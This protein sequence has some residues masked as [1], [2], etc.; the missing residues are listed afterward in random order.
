M[1]TPES[2]AL[3]ACLAGASFLAPGTLADVSLVEYRV[4]RDG[5]LGTTLPAGST[6]DPATGLGALTL[7]FDTAGPHYGGLFVDHEL[8]EALNTFFNETG[9]TSAGALPAGL[10]YEIDE[11]DLVTGNIYA[12]F[13][14]NTLDNGVGTPNTVFPDDVSMALMWNIVLAAGETAA[15]E[16]VVSENPLA[17]FYLIHT[18]P[19]SQEALYFGS[20]LTIRASPNPSG[21]EIPEPGTVAAGLAFAALA[22]GCTVRRT[23]R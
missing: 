15:V 8:S 18:D 6:F 17:G 23:R 21:G 9:A 12:N 11:P 22:A 16:F 2:R 10:S 4:N 14:A 5:A 1:K 7:T 13:A 19:D 20:T 3:A